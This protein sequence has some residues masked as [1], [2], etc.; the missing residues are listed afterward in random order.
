MPEHVYDVPYFGYEKPH[1]DALVKMHVRKSNHLQWKCLRRGEPS[2]IVASQ[3]DAA[4]DMTEKEWHNARG[5]G[6]PGCGK[7]TI[8]RAYCWFYASTLRLNVIHIF[9]NSDMASWALLRPAADGGCEAC[10]GVLRAYEQF[11]VLDELI[12]MLNG[13]VS[14]LVLDGLRNDETSKQWVRA[15]TTTSK[16]MNEPYRIIFMS[17]LQMDLKWNDFGTSLPEKIEPT[18][19]SWSLEEYH[20]ACGNDGLWQS[21]SQFILASPGDDKTKSIKN[22]FAYAG[23]SARWMFSVT[24]TTVCQII[25]EAVEKVQSFDDLIAGNLGPKSATTVNSLRGIRIPSALQYKGTPQLVSRYAYQAIARYASQQVASE[26]WHWA[27]TTGNNAFIGWAYEACCISN[28]VK[29]EA[30]VDL[31]CEY[32][33]TV[34]TEIY[35]KSGNH[36]HVVKVFSTVQPFRLKFPKV[37]ADGIHG[38]T[39]SSQILI[40]AGKKLD[41]RFMIVPVSCKHPCFDIVFVLDQHVYCIQC[42]I[43]QSH[44]RKLAAIASLIIE[45]EKY[46]K[47]VSVHLVACVH[48]SKFSSFEFEDPEFVDLGRK[49][50]VCWKCSHS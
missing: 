28:W 7:S 31:P 21:V 3:G 45:I 23:G 5:E 49:D 48:E 10:Y 13:S 24:L 27:Q 9:L 41:G 29:G 30:C 18:F 1:K 46:I 40:P 43:K 11:D 19:E 33:N 16:T 2:V 35:G 34:T 17:S 32:L 20:Q 47:V 14:L 26:L 39:L 37:A 6:P 15:A 4:A 36:K 42:T 22:K 44:S 50:I 25:D 12:S 8:L 38:L